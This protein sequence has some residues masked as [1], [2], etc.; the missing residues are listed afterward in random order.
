M[1]LGKIPPAGLSRIT[2]ALRT[3]RPDST[4]TGPDPL[5]GPAVAVAV[6]PKAQ[7]G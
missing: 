4:I 3:L 6:A 2:E 7:L 1:D 5:N